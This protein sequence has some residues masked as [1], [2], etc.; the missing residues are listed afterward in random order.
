MTYMYPCVM[1]VMKFKQFVDW[2]HLILVYHL[3]NYPILKTIDTVQENIYMC[4]A[5]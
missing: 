3:E 1:C 4:N 2:K 5:M